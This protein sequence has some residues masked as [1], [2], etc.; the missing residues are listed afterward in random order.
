[1]ST[2]RKREAAVCVEQASMFLRMAGN[3]LLE[4]K[5]GDPFAVSLLSQSV[6]LHDTAQSMHARVDRIEKGGI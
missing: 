2:K 6:K 5:P 3:A 1:M 4:D